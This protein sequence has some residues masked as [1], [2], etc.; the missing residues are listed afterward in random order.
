MGNPS[1]LELGGYKAKNSRT[2]AKKLEDKDL[3][4]GEVIRN[5]CGAKN[6]HLKG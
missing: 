4:L 2:T 5:R 6:L 3:G 1:V